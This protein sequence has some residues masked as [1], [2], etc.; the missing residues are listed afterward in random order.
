MSDT[1]TD[2]AITI[3]EFLEKTP[4]SQQKK[5]RGLLKNRVKSTGLPFGEIKISYFS[6]PFGEI[7]LDCPSA[8][9][10][11]NRFFKCENDRDTWTIG[12]DW[13]S[14]FLHYKCR[15][16]KEYDKTFAIIIKENESTEN[17]C[18][19][20]K[21]GEWPTF[22]PRTPA[23]VINMIGPDKDFFLKGRRSEIAGL[24]IGAFS[25]YRRLIENQ[26]ERLIENIIKVAKITDYNEDLIA[27]LE[28]AK[29]E[30]QFSKSIELIKDNIPPEL[31]IEKSNP[32]TLL[33]KALSVGI[34]T[35]SD[36][37]CLEYAASIR[38][39]LSEL[40]SRIS[41]ALKDR[42]AVKK[43]IDKLNKTKS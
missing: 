20:I 3:T 41:K 38:T 26:K 18:D 4:P 11:G 32:L 29:I 30:D 8:S 14:L 16:C 28:K 2:K 10:N 9:C 15:N 19:V 23:R 36:E 35:L 40:A 33:H 42:T 17:N 37:A 27:N 34:H 39:V 24:G 31:F 43:A 12:S 22:G 21:L 13:E 25:Y 1:K 5:I 6:L 7:T